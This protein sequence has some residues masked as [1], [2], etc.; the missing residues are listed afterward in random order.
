MADFFFQLCFQQIYIFPFSFVYNFVLINHQISRP[1]KCVPPTYGKFSWLSGLQIV[2]LSKPVS[3][4][5]YLLHLWLEYLED[6]SY[7]IFI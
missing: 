3:I 7:S 1:R 5:L 2:S 4:F 6:F